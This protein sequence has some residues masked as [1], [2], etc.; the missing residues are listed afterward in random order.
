MEATDR[1]L[2]EFVPEIALEDVCYPRLTRPHE[3]AVF[4]A[5]G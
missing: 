1:L 5:T 4:D 3:F 2:H